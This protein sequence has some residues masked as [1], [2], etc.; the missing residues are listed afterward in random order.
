MRKL[1]LLTVIAIATVGLHAGIKV[2]DVEVFSGYPWKEVVVGYRITGIPD[3]NA[4]Y[5][6]QLTATDKLSKKNYVAATLS[7][8]MLTVGRHVVRW[9]AASEGVKFSS[10]DVVFEVSVA[11]GVQLWENGP[12]WAECNVGA[13]KP[14]DA[15][16]YFCWGDTVGYKRVDSRWDA[17]DGSMRGFSFNGGN[18]PTYRKDPATLTS[19]GYIDAFNLIAKYDAATQHIGAPW[20]MPT[21]A[22]WDELIRNCERTFTTRHGVWG[23]LVTGRDS[24]SSKSI[25]LPATGL[26][27]GFDLGGVDSCGY[28]W[29]S[30]TYAEGDWAAQGLY[31][32]S[33]NVQA[34]GN[35]RYYGRSVRPILGNAQ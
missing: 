29:S 19:Q 33:G 23:L 6:G 35:G 30:S 28:Y 17:V 3:N 15:G 1:L 13:E 12:Y 16:Y 21:R 31:F 24:Y 2:S 7:D 34:Y 11:S 32:N 22:E 26:G 20:R 27:D 25:F 5:W 14:E 8:A 9:N 4:S 10:A 18:C